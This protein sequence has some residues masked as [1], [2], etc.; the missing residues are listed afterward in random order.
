MLESRNE[1]KQRISTLESEAVELQ[2]DLTAA[3]DRAE[4][5]EANL[6]ESQKSLSE[7]QASNSTLSEAN[8]A[9][10]TEI[11]SLKADLTDE[12]I[13]DRI[14]ETLAK[15]EEDNVL[16]VAIEEI[17][18]NRMASAGHAPVKEPKNGGHAL[19]IKEQYKALPPGP[20]R[21]AFRDKHA[22]ELGA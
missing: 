16:H 6:A 7:S 4:K 3:N 10:L 13:A 22:A 11:A 21:K 20:E 2:N 19:T 18:T 15:G 5:A 1:L 14:K 12:A 9:K 8:E 17:V